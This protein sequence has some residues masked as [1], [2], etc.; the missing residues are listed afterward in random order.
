MAARNARVLRGRA[1]AGAASIDHGDDVDGLA[2]P[3]DVGRG[4]TRSTFHRRIV[5]RLRVVTVTGCPRRL[6]GVTGSLSK[7]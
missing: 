6:L 4:Q 5:S 1:G 3:V 7:R 2:P